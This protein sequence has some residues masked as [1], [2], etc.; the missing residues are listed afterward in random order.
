MKMKMEELE[1]NPKHEYYKYNNWIDLKL[2]S[3]FFLS[4]LIFY[5]QEDLQ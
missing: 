4:C 5:C 1:H 2:F 3:Y